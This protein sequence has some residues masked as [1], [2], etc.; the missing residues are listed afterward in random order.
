M[1]SA[2]IIQTSRETDKHREGTNSSK[3]NTQ[4]MDVDREEQKLEQ[5]QC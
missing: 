4:G 1:Y 5:I 2:E 3:R